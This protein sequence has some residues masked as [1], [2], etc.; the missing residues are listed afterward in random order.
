MNIFW[1]GWSLLFEVEKAILIYNIGMII[2]KHV[3]ICFFILGTILSCTVS[4]EFNLSLWK[5]YQ[6][7]N[8]HLLLSHSSHPFSIAFAD[9]VQKEWKG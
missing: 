8:P 2:K 7:N 3:F 5:N 9:R 1:N 4:R 6:L